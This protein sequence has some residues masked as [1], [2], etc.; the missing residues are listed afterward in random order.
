MRR[1]NSR[2]AVSAVGLGNPRPAQLRPCSARSVY[3]VDIE[4][5]CGLSPGPDTAESGGVSARCSAAAE[6]RCEPI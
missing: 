4:F 2:H 3:V 5:S 6:S 1:A